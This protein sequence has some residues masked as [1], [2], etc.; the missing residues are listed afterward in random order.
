MQ[1]QFD[2]TQVCFNASLIST[3]NSRIICFISAKNRKIWDHDGN[4]NEIQKLNLESL[5]VNL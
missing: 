1:D 4:A 5:K 2:I 3:K